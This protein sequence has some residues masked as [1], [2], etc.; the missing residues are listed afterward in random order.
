MKILYVDDIRT[1]AY[2]KQLKEDVTIVRNYKDAIFALKNNYYDYVSLDHDLGEKK[3][4]Y[5]ITKYI[6]E[7]NINIGVIIIHSANVVGKYNMKQ[8]LQHYGYK[9]V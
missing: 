2:Y 3:T 8:L 9:V 7:N 1:P 6:V 5:D 4:G